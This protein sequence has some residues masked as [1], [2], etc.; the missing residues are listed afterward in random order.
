M[1]RRRSAKWKE[2]KFEPSLLLGDSC[3]EST[4]GEI[5]AVW[6]G[7]IPGMQKKFLAGSQKIVVGNEDIISSNLDNPSVEV[8]RNVSLVISHDINVEVL[9][10]FTRDE[11]LCV[12]K[13]MH[14]D[15]MQF[16]TNAFG[17]SSVMR[18]HYL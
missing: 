12:L 18:R 14:P 10:P 13:Q 7:L 3:G 17:I 16:S 4:M 1:S 2:P 5:S 6:R 9:K 15:D 8:L 11:I